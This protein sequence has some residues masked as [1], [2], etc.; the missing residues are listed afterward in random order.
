MKRLALFLLLALGAVAASPTPK[1]APAATPDFTATSD[2]KWGVYP[3]GYKQIITE[4]LE[5]KLIDPQSAAIEFLTEPRKA[6]LTGKGDAKLF[7][8][9][10]ELRVNARNKF[11]APT[12]WQKRWVLIRNG[13]ILK[14][15][16]GSGS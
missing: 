7:G 12:G 10:V 4:W 14:D 9:Y 5:N 1:P 2:S 8:Y 6:G 13:G 15:G 3:I 11:G 16:T